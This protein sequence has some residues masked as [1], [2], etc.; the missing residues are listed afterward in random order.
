MKL[1]FEKVI[2]SERMFEMLKK[3]LKIL[4]AI[5]MVF[6]TFAPPVIQ[7]HYNDFNDEINF[8]DYEAITQ[9]LSMSPTEFNNAFGGEPD[10]RFM[11]F[12]LVET[13]LTMH[14]IEIEGN[15]IDLDLILAPVSIF[16][17][18]VDVEYSAF[19]TR[20]NGNQNDL[21]ITVTEYFEDGGINKLTDTFRIDNNGSGLFI[22]GNYEIFINTQGND[23]IRELRMESDGSR[24]IPIRGTLFN[25]NREGAV[26]VEVE[27]LVN[28]YELLLF[29]INTTPETHNL[30]LPTSYSEN[31]YIVPHAKIYLMDEMGQLHL[32]EL[33]VP[34]VLSQLSP[35][36]FEELSHSNDFLW[37]I[38]VVEPIIEVF[39]YEELT[40]ELLEYLGIGLET[41][42]E[43]FTPFNVSE[44][45]IW[46]TSEYTSVAFSVTTIAGNERAVASSRPTMRRRHNN[47]GRNATNF[48]DVEF[49]VVESL[50]LYAR[51]GTAWR[52]LRTDNGRINGVIDYR[53]IEAR[54]Q[55][56]NHTQIN[57]FST[58]GRARRH[59]TVGSTIMENRSSIRSIILSG[60]GIPSNAQ[61]A[62]T[63]IS[64]ALGQSSQ[65]ITLGSTSNYARSGNW[66]SVGVRF[67]NTYRFYHNTSSTNGH[68][69]QLQVNAGRGGTSNNSTATVDGAARV[70][71]EVFIN[72]SRQG[73]TRHIAR[74]FRYT[75]DRRN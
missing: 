29:E 73:S 39:E 70:S 59:N 68:R 74:S 61:S 47:I 33:D 38:S 49:R 15:S 65:N 64:G 44:A 27:D 17:T 72:N 32:F 26:V 10:S 36:E 51:N 54:I 35:L 63:L 20:L 30:L 42:N 1:L 58:H 21:T 45:G 66:T 4:L 60:I 56:G 55:L 2:I 34:D 25:G 71:F 37:T 46:I 48:F 69:L 52:H 31:L 6:G 3:S 75:V 18:I 28:G 22:I 14:N 11:S 7:A 62:L 50:R 23:R 43:L 13:K 16:G 40:E 19:I 24:I 12:N 9:G 53:N 8:T 57:N 67:P 5:L 41:S